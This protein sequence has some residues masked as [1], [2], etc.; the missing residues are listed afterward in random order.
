MT[1]H[2]LQIDA[3]NMIRR[4]YG[5]N[6]APD[7]VD[8]ANAAMK[9]TVG[10]FKRAL[11]RHKPTHCLW[12]FDAG[13][14]TW[15]HE[16]YPPYKKDRK[17]MPTELAEALPEFK[18]RLRRH[19]WAVATVPGFEAEDVLASVGVHAVGAGMKVTTLS[20]DK[21]T[22]CLSAKSILVYDHFKDRYIDDAFCLQ[23]W[24]ITAD[25][26]P[27]LLALWGD[28]VDG[29]PGVDEIADKRAASL[30]KT[31]GSLEQVLQNADTVSGVVGKNLRAQA[32]QARLSRRLVTLREDVLESL[33]RHFNPDRLL[34]G[35][36]PDT[37][38]E[39]ASSATLRR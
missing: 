16:I 17:P 28:Q 15:R 4:V 8:K 2:L 36:L 21:D 3:F 22:F 13:G 29:V 12:A 33:G 38:A 18:D 7:S 20:N 25:R 6:P 10:S 11:D 24:G 27:D 1:A 35:E 31:Y 32:D 9:A 19:G 14:Q 30:L 37:T 26:V 5:G 39:K 23:K 34:V